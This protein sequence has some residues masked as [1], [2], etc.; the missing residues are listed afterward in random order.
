MLIKQIRIAMPA[1]G[2]SN[3]G[4]VPTV[5]VRDGNGSA[6]LCFLEQLIPIDGIDYALLTPV[7]TPVSLFQLK[8]EEYVVNKFEQ[9]KNKLQSLSKKLNKLQTTYEEKNNTFLLS[10][11]V[12]AFIGILLVLTPW[13]GICCVRSVS[14][15][16]PQVARST[17]IIWCSFSFKYLAIALA[18]YNSFLCRCP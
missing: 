18:A 3:N 9:L 15:E 7:D 16:P 2:P 1:P 6:L 11:S 5:L 17:L 4:E 8:D 13:V 14:D 10:A 12:T